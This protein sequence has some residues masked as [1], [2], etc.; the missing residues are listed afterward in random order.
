[1]NASVVIHGVRGIA[2]AGILAATAPAQ[3]NAAQSCDTPVKI[4]HG[5][6]SPQVISSHAPESPY[7]NHPGSHIYTDKQ[8]VVLSVIVGTNG[9]ACNPQVERS[10]RADFGKAAVDAIRDWKWKPAISGGT[11]VAVRIFVE[12][13]FPGG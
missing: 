5:V 13:T 2:L 8:V 1:M 9:V 4:R 6:T 7:A 11:P 12:M 3:S 10:A